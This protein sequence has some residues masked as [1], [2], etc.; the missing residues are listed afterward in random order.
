MSRSGRSPAE[1]PNG[2]TT[3]LRPMESA[4][5]R[6]RYPLYICLSVLFSALVLAAGATIAW[7][8][9]AESRDI[10][11]AAA[12]DAFGHIG[13]ETQSSLRESFQPVANLAE[14]LALQP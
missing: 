10:A 9:Y 6:R 2:S 11:L 1:I 5:T 13:R 3:R 4:A 7:L 8:G 12:D 14:L